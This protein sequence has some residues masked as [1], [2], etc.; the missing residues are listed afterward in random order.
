MAY[1]QL[2]AKRIAELLMKD[3]VAFE[4]RKMFGG[5]AFMMQ[6]KMCIGVMKNELMLRVLDEKYQST[7]NMDHVKPMEFTGRTLKNFVLVEAKGLSTE[8]TLKRWIAPG[9]EFGK[10]GKLKNR[11]K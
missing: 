1:D 9:I 10:I 2:L 6:H 11:K 8:T 3:H 4:E 7:L 5:I